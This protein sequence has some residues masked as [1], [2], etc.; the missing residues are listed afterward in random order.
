MNSHIIVGY[1]GI[2]GQ[3]EATAHRLLLMILVFDSPILTP[4]KVSVKPYG[5]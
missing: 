1:M 5:A 2:D 3:A 4:Y